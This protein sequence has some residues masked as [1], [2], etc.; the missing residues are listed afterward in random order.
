MMCTM[1]FAALNALLSFGDDQIMWMRVPVEDFSHQ[2]LQESDVMRKSLVCATK[3]E[4]CLIIGVRFGKQW[5]KRPM[6]A[7]I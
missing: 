5:S 6:D 1:I 7:R 2:R 4:Q 3:D